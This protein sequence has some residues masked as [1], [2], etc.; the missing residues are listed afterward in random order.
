MCAF[1]IF[2]LVYWRADFRVERSCKKLQEAVNCEKHLSLDPPHSFLARGESGAD[3]TESSSLGV[4][5]WNGALGE[6][7]PTK[8]KVFGLGSC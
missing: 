3:H 6:P 2:Y 8:E 5:A 4:M 7:R 1:L